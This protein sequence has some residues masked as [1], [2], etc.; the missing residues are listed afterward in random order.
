[1]MRMIM[2]MATVGVGLFAVMAVAQDAAP[3][4]TGAG[5][6]MSDAEI[7]G[8]TLGTQFGK[9]MKKGGDSI[10]REKFIQGFNDALDDKTIAIDEER[11]RKVMEDFRKNAMLK[12]QEENKKTAEANLQQQKTFFEENGKKEGVVSLPSGLQYKVITEGAGASP[13]VTDRIKINYRGTFPDGK[14]FDSSYKRG[15][16]AE[17]QVNKTIPGWKEALPLMKTGAKWELYIPSE[18]AYGVMGRQPHIPPNQMLVF[19]VELLE[20]LPPQEADIPATPAAPGTPP[21]PVTAP[22]TPPADAGASS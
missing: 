10:D 20:V 18:L 4:P 6:E 14:E 16:P 17:L 2:L 11:V 3:A 1:M 8:Y 12:Q 5:A 13:S 21:P 7:V 22:A 15:K 9:G 19:E